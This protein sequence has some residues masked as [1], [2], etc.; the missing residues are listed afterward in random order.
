MDDG[1]L[2]RE[3]GRPRRASA[4]AEPGANVSLQDGE[5]I[6]LSSD[7]GSRSAPGRDL[8]SDRGS[9]SAPGRELSSDR[10]SRSAP[11]RELSSDRGS[12]SAPGG[13]RTA[14]GRPERRSSVPGPVHQRHMP[15]E[16]KKFQIPRKTKEKKCRFI[17]TEPGFIVQLF[18]NSLDVS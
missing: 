14:A 4:A 2:W 3:T 1:L 7:R 13:G 10:G 5:L 17:R 6:E 16:P 9:R 18:L 8:S 11:G 12:R 15:M